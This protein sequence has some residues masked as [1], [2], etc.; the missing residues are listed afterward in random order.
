VAGSG[1]PLLGRLKPAASGRWENPASAPAS[2][3]SG[4]NGNQIT[5]AK[6]NGS[7]VIVGVNAYIKPA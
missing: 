1:L 2:P 6:V 5:D 4:G 7:P 3:I